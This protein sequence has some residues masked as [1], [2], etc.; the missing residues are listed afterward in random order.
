[1]LFIDVIPEHE[2]AAPVTHELAFTAARE[3]LVAACDD[4][5]TSFPV[6]LGHG[7]SSENRFT[8][9]A[10]ATADVTGLQVGS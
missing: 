2:S 3:A 6:V 8:V 1:M 9:K 7:S 10:A 5:T 4:R